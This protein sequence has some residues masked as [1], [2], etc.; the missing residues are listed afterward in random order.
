[1]KTLCLDGGHGA[2]DPGAI[3]TKT[4]LK[5]KDVVLDVVLR[6]RRLL[7]SEPIKVV[8]TR[9]D[10]TFISLTQRAVISNNAA[11]D[12]F[13]SVHCN[14]AEAPT[15]KGFE[16]FTS[17][18]QTK[19]DVPATKLINRYKAEFPGLLLR[20]DWSDGDPDKEA[21]FTVLTATKAPAVLLELEFI[22]TKE[23]SEFLSSSANKDRIAKVIA[24]W[25]KEILL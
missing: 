9:S 10:D 13:L 8:L 24:E 14:S 15:A 7:L 17:P 22:H 12:L 2:H 16:A 25:A 5:E 19:A 21:R 1:M 20:A 3:N 6:A 11:A 4:K 23:G 18:G